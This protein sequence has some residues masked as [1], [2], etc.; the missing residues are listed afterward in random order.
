MEV[1]NLLRL[2][3]LKYSFIFPEMAFEKILPLKQETDEINI[4]FSFDF[5]LSKKLYSHYNQID[6]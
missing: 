6:D 3:L 1:T 5:V 2:R 4:W